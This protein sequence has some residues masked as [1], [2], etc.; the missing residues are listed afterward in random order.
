MRGHNSLHRNKPDVQHRSMQP[1]DGE[2][3]KWLF[4][5]NALLNELYRDDRRAAYA[6][7]AA[8]TPLADEIAIEPVAVDAVRGWWARPPHA[9]SGKGIFFVHGGGFHLGDAKSH[10]GFVSQ[11]A[12]LT[13][14]A[15]FSVDYALA[16]ERR[17]PAAI[18]DV[19]KAQGWFVSQD[20]HEYSAIGDSAGGGLVLAMA[21]HPTDSAA[22]LSS[23]V[24]FSPWTDLSNSGRSFRDP[25]THDPIFT[26]AVLDGLAASYLDGRNARDP[27]ASPL[28]G[29]PKELP[30]V[31]IQVGSEELLR[32]DSTRYAELAAAKGTDVRLD[33]YDGL[34][35]VFQRDI[36]VLDTARVA[37]ERASAFI[38]S[39]WCE[40]LNVGRPVRN[41]RSTPCAQA[42]KQY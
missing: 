31:Y 22:T 30:P 36:G 27:D 14:C 1:G 34:H 7:M 5:R 42:K 3:Q 16:P 17:F 11:I 25:D 40:T 39:S 28:F 19:R 26:P 12:A 41:Q 37:V 6:A 38:A 4:R 21:A 23:V 10:L 29:I 20:I 13:Q 33:I 32:D 9:A 2:R 35:H 24:V 15:V 18:D 8:Q